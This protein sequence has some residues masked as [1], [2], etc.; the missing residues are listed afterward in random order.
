MNV[1]RHPPPAPRQR[2]AILEEVERLCQSDAFRQ[3]RQAVKLLRYLVE[4]TL[5]DHDELLRERA[6][7]ARVF[8]RD[9]RYDTNEDSI[10]RVGVADVRKRLTRAYHDLDPKPPVERSIPLGSYRVE[11]KVA[12]AVAPPAL[13]SP[14]PPPR[15]R[16]PAVLAAVVTLG[17]ALFLFSPPSA[18]D[19]FWAPALQDPDPVVILAPHPTVYTFSRETFRRFRGDN[20]SH[21]QRQ[22][23]ALQAPPDAS[24][25]VSE[26]VTIRDQYLGLGSA[27][28]IADLAAL[29]AVRKKSYKIRF[30]GDHSFQELR[31]APVVLIGA[32][33]NR[34]TL[35]LTDELR[36]VLS[37][38][39]SVPE[40]LD[41]REGRS[42]SV[43]QLR[44]DGKTPEDYVLVSRLFHPKTG[45]LLL[46]LAGITQY[47]T[48]AA[49]EF[50]T[51]P[52]LLEEATRLAP[53]GWE[54]RNVQFVLHVSVLEGM[55]SRPEV[56]AAHFW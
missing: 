37:E 45:R 34:W 6:I 19:R 16:L 21:A 36:F 51:G 42:W 28:A 52:A 4:N 35:Y 12:A 49:G 5:D 50:V 1:V 55:P 20:P 10:V 56:V 24:I 47:G 15:W 53:R 46:A 26:V 44:P 39:D 18:V 11:F 13:V 9:A 32:Y 54:R 30:G 25:P 2:A 48:Q 41:R 23:E 14:R 43:P 3:S 22:I 29:F 27:H 38:R 8:G 17:G 33:A 31:Q 7:G 40:I